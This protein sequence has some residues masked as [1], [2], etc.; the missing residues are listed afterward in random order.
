MAEYEI[1]VSVSDGQAAARTDTFE[2]KVVLP[3]N[4]PPSAP[5]L[6]PLSATEDRSFTYQVPAFT[7][8]DED[9]LIYGASLE[10]GGSLPE[11]LSF[12]AT[13]RTFS[14]TPLEDDTPASHTIRVTAS[15]DGEPPKSASVTFSLTVAEINDAPSTPSLMD[16]TAQEGQPFSYTFE[17]VADPENGSVTYTATLGAGGELPPWLSFDVTSLTLSGT[18]GQS[19]APAELEIRITATDDGDPPLG[20]I[21][22]F[23][24]T[25][26]EEN[27]APV[28]ADDAATVA[29]GEAV[30]IPSAD[31]LAND[32]DPNGDE[33]EVI[34]VWDALYGTVVLSPDGSS[35][36]YTHGGS[37]NPWGSFTYTVGDGTA[38]GHRHRCRHRYPGK[39]PATGAFRRRP[40]RHR[41]S[42]V[43]ISG[44]HPVDDPEGDGVTYGAALAGNGALPGWLNFAAET[45]TFSGMPLEADTPAALTIFVTA[46][47]RRRA[48]TD[49]KC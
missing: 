16:Q 3:P 23:T 13:T 19:D 2:L 20:A 22:D 36:T 9:T 46:S 48:V 31:L 8:L 18:P 21:G 12:S 1:L 42:A 38:T 34:G 32:S 44:L 27:G 26:V 28:A 7:D 41:R 11:W 39:R 35:V 15:D 6:S 17:A 25:V 10:D 49:G 43:H 45:R 4:R 5:A 24:L 30:T 47:R 40:D 14:G 29:E 37:E 33:L